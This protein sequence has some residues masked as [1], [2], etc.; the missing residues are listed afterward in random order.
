MAT[1]REP[2]QLPLFVLTFRVAA[3]MRQRFGELLAAQPWVPGGGLRPPCYGVM[4]FIAQRETVSQKALSEALGLH[5]SDMVGIVDLLE[6]NG[7][8]VRERAAG[9]RRRNVIRL[10][11]AGHEAL[12]R[13][14]EV[15]D[16]VEASLFSD[17]SAADRKALR[18]VLNRLVATV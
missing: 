6:S 18:A 7:W 8:V 12:R 1:R 5:Q 4:R 16:D 11:D 3:A 2:D 9:D 15:A 13:L 14:D 17:V 10:T